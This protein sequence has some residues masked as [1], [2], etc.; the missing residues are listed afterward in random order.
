MRQ[1]RWFPIVTLGLGL[2]AINAVARVVIRI[3]FNDDDTG[4]AQDRISIAMFAVVGIVLVGYVFL[5]SQR[6]APGEWA[7][8][9]AGS[10]L[11]GMLLTV[12]VG[13]FISGDSPF[14]DGAGSFFSQIWV[15][16]GV[17]I[18]AVLLG[19]WIATM[20]GRD[21]RSRS[22]KAFAAARTSKPRRVVRR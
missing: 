1:Q 13:P 10:A 14:T 21:Y 22:L 16:G 6:V 4:T 8:A 15:Y 20:L 18:V 11:I 9:V 19:Y 2:F 3:F 5:R 7:P 12:L 17:A